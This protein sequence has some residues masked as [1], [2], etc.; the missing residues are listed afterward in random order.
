MSMPEVPILYLQTPG[1]CGV[2]VGVQESVCIP[3]SL[4]IKLSHLYIFDDALVLN[5][6]FR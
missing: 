2:R 3:T 4:G 1:G 6:L 5:A